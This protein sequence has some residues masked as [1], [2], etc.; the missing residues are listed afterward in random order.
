MG[1]NK[2]KGGG[3]LQQ[4]PDPKKQATFGAFVNNPQIPPNIQQQ[5]NAHPAQSNNDK[6]VKNKPIFVRHPLP[7]LKAFIKTLTLEKLP[8]IT[9]QVIK[10]TH[11]PFQQAKVEALSVKDKTT[12]IAK[13]KESKIAHFTFTEKNEKLASFVLK[14]H[15][16]TSLDDIK[17]ILSEQLQVKTVKFIK[18][19]KNIPIYLVQFDSPNINL[20]DL[21]NKHQLMAGCKVRW[22]AL[23]E[24]KKKFTQ[25][26]RCQRWGHSSTNCGFEF[27]CVAC[28]ESNHEPGKCPRKNFM[29]EELKDTAKCANCGLNHAANY[30]QCVAFKQ[31]QAF[32]KAARDFRTHN[33]KPFGHKFN[34]V[35]PHPPINNPNVKPVTAAQPMRYPPHHPKPPTADTSHHQLDFGNIVNHPRAPKHTE[36]PLY[37]DASKFG[38]SS[39]HSQ[40]RTPPTN[41]CANCDALN[42]RVAQLEEQLEQLNQFIRAQF[43]DQTLNN[44]G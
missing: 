14:G 42:K 3:H 28:G 15:Y 35:P 31:Y 17:D 16:H 36:V 8:T 18:D 39:S 40:S 19:D 26:H 12:I 41:T 43:S 21:N 27:R 33:K 20:I 23:Q 25:C 38:E 7:E 11:G 24:S 30:K 44:Y 34:P 2:R 13:L 10:G 4:P 29:E 1:Q 32:I 9:Y 22:E 5:S 37:R 6:Q